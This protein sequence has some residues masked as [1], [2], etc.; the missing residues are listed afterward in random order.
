MRPFFLAMFLA[1]CA[2]PQHPETVAE[3][4]SARPAPPT[5][6]TIEPSGFAT[7]LAAPPVP[8]PETP[9]PSDRGE[10]EPERIARE[11]GISVAEAEAR[12]NPD[13]STMQA[14]MALRDRLA[15]GAAGNFV[16][17]RIVRDPAPRYVFHFRRFAAATLARF[18]SDPRFAAVEGGVPAAE[19]EPLLREWLERFRPHR[20]GSAASIDPFEGRV[21]IEAGVSRPEFETV[22]AREG[23][24]LPDRIRLRF[25]PE[26]DES[27]AVAPDAAPFVR[28]FPR[29]DREPG[30]VL[31]SATFGRLVLGDGCFRIDDARSGPLVLF[32]RN[33][34]LHRD[35]EGYLAVGSLANQRQ[36]A[37]VGERI[38]WGGHPAGS[39]DSPGVRAIRARCGEGPI[40]S[41]G[42]PASA[43]VFRVRPWA[44]DEYVR[45]RRISRQRAWDEIRACWAEQDAR[46]EADRRPRRDCDLPH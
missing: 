1:A 3:P 38:V 36:S 9:P 4:A 25:A 14:A 11:N 20:L 34:R 45:V 43:H 32:G 42:E 2:V 10:S 33:A 24:V 27:A 46:P 6:A 35:S 16:D 17:V 21:E 41:V 13:E 29:A 26:I 40:V 28:I 30:V 5:G 8:Y 37:R 15:R 19:L 22:A 7:I 31:G 12:M 39:E 23:W 18:S 44:I